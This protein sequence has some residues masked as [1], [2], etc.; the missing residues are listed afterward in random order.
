M[1]TVFQL[2]A[3]PGVLNF[4]QESES[5]DPGVPARMSAPTATA[6][7]A[8]ATVTYG[9]ATSDWPNAVTG[10]VVTAYPGGLTATVGN[11]LTAT[12]TGLTNGI[13]YSFTVHAINVVGNGAESPQ[14]NTVIPVATATAPSAPQNLSGV[15]GNGSIFIAWSPPASTGGSALTGYDVTTSPV[16]TTTSVGAGTN[17]TTLSGLV[18]GTVYTISVVAKNAIGNSS[19]ATV[20]ITPDSSGGGATCQFNQGFN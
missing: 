20:V 11:V 18:N 13:S 14:S 19:P 2:Y 17:N 7:N 5:L 6:G 1:P 12:V 10:Y 4:D 8:Q 16:T 15:G 3:H 9:A